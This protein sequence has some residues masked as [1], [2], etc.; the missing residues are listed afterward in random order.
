MKAD[1]I[2]ATV[3]PAWPGNI[4]DTLN[5]VYTSEFILIAAN[6]HTCRSN[7]VSFARMDR[8]TR[9]ETTILEKTID[10]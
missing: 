4:R 8:K 9:R 2:R 5:G 1:D 10:L 6:F 3:T 7:V